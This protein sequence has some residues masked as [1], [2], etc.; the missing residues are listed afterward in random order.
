MAK[1]KG[2]SLVSVIKWLNQSRDAAL[3]ALPTH[4][5]HY[6]DE[7]I[8]VANWYPEQDL[9][10]MIRSLASILPPNQ[11]KIYEQMGRVSAREQFA[12]VYRHLLEGGDEFSLPRRG[13]VLW[14][15]QHDSGRLSMKMA[16][17]SSRDDRDRRLRD[18]QPRDVPDPPRLHRRDVRDGRVQGPGRVQ[19][20]LPPRGRRPL[21][22]GRSPGRP[23]R[24]PLRP[25]GA[26]RRPVAWPRRAAP[27]RLAAPR[28]R[29]P[30]AGARAR[31]RTPASRRRRFDSA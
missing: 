21:L 7:R 5:H 29:A 19:D 12:G 11:G 20:G 9:V 25:R 3:K 10:E 27:A 18:S 30:R 23:R 4:L 6:L 13:L 15:S 14:Q 31:A 22:A 16:G 1:A 17:T 28:P 24:P 2:S 26:E 8:Q